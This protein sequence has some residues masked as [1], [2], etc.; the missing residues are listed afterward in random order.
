[1]MTWPF[2]TTN[3][4]NSQ[5]W[6]QKCQLWSSLKASF[7]PPKGILIPADISFLQVSAARASVAF[8]WACWPSFVFLSSMYIFGG[9]SGVLLNDVLAY[10]PPSCQ[11][12]SSP[13]GCAAAGPGVR[14]HWV[15]SRCLPWEPKQPLLNIPA[16]F[17]PARPGRLHY[18]PIHACFFCLSVNIFHINIILLKMYIII[19]LH[20][21]CSLKASCFI[22]IIIIPK[23]SGSEG[24]SHIVIIGTEG[25]RHNNYLILK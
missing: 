14:C 20:K 16:P 11:A 18:H 24:C 4:P 13:A 19:F 10:T 12:F 2:N 6:A 25:Q 17:C 5:I 3:P 23:A 7:H 15:K 1:M 21:C 8:I 9:F 22:I